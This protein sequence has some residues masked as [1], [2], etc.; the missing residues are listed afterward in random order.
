[1]FDQQEHRQTVEYGADVERVLVEIERDPY[2]ESGRVM[3]MFERWAADDSIDV[4]QFATAAFR[5][6]R[7]RQRALEAEDE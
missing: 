4:E 7:A 6:L 5:V 3:E 1:M 2:D